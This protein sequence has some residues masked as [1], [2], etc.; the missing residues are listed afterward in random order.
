ML[1]ESDVHL[2]EKGWGRIVLAASASRAGT[3]WT[4]HGTA[5]QERGKPRCDHV[6]TA[7]QDRV[8]GCCCAAEAWAGC[9]VEGE[10]VVR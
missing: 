9:G 2:P 4:D 8:T 3:A 5:R 7:G 1:R 10:G 6:L